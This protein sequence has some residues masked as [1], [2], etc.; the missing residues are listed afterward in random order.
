MLEF[1][2]YVKQLTRIYRPYEQEQDSHQ[3]PTA[4]ILHHDLE[5]I[6]KGSSHGDGLSNICNY[7]GHWINVDIS[8]I[9]S[10]IIAVKYSGSD[11]HDYRLHVV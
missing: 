4:N 6:C 1:T 10:I 5:N 7:C 8:I 11:I 2:Q 3:Q 9:E